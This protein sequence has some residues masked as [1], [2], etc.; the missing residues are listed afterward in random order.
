MNFLP[1]NYDDFLIFDQKYYEYFNIKKEFRRCYFSWYNSFLCADYDL[2]MS[3]I[4][5]WCE[6]EGV[7]VIPGDVHAKIILQIKLENWLSKWNEQKSVD[8]L[9]NYIIDTAEELKR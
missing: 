2:S 9:Y 4:L 1:E 8:F 3:K 6:E 7:D 5:E